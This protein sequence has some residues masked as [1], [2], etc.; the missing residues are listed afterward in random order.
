MCCWLLIR[1]D[2]LLFTSSATTAL[3]MAIILALNH[4]TEQVVKAALHLLPY[5]AWVGDSALQ[6]SD[7]QCYDHNVC[8]RFHLDRHYKQ[9]KFS[10]LTL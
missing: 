9:T 8:M 10:L 3:L 4:S 1:V 7:E 5:N 6:R 2:H